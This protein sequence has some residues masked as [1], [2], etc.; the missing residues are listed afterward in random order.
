MKRIVGTAP[1]PDSAERKRIG[2]KQT[3]LITGGSRGIGRA[4]ALRFA[5][6]GSWRIV[7]TSRN[8]DG[9]LFRAESALRAL[10]DTEVL[11]VPGDIADEAFVTELFTRT[12]R[13]FGAP[14]CLINNAGVDSSGLLQETPT[15]EWDRVMNVNLR[16]AFFTM[17]AVIPLML[18]RHQG[19]IV[20][21]SSVWGVTGGSFESVYSASKGGLIA[22]TRAM[23]KELAPSGIRVNAAAFGAID[24]QMNDR[25]SAE[26]KEALAEEIPLGRMGTAEEAAELLYGLA[27]RHP[28]MTG[29]V[30]TL[31]GGW[32]V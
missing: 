10:P 23:A 32:T 29:Q 8:T 17:R 25:L 1:V 20:N 4:C 11:A 12:D 18:R 21:V 16:S 5:A 30:V 2:M 19:S 22:L 26:E 7:I 28:Y 14:D 3:V 27:V 13:A 24:T 9:S 31:D 6:A 15:A